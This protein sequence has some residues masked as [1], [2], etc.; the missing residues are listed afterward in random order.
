MG[1]PE[2]HPRAFHALVDGPIR[3]TMTV[4]T[5][6]AMLVRFA[7]TGYRLVARDLPEGSTSRDAGDRDDYSRAREAVHDRGRD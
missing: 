1:A 6:E 3:S 7:Q 5:P 2:L 4:V